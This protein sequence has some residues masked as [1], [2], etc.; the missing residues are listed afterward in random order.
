MQNHTTTQDPRF[1]AIYK[2]HDADIIS[3]RS[4]DVSLN[5]LTGGQAAAGKEI[6]I[7]QTSHAFLF[8]S[9]GFGVIPLVN[10]FLKGEEKELSEKYTELLLDLCNFVTLPF[11]WGGFEPKRGEPNTKAI[12]AA[13]RWLKDRGLTVKGHPLCWHTLCAPWLLEMDNSEILKTQLARIERDVTD[14]KG[15]IDMWDVINEAVIMPIFD[16][17]DNG[18]TR[19][20]NEIGRLNLIRKTFEEA[21]KANS[22]ATL[23]INDFD[24]T[25]PYEILI[26]GCL[27]AGIPIDCIGIQSHMHQGYW[28][29]EKTLQILERYER[30]GL[31]IHFSETTIISGD[32]MPGEIVDL[33]DYKRDSWPSTPEGEERQAE[34]TVLHYRTLFSRKLVK[35]ITWWDLIDG[36]WLNAPSGLIRADCS[37][38]PAYKELLKLIKEEWRGK[39]T[40]LAADDSGTI[41]FRAF[42]GTYEISV[43]GKTTR[44]EI[45]GD[46]SVSLSASL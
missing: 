21:R 46:G 1:T 6:T 15:V 3:A 8:G 20:C 38:K 36:H 19:V 41:R 12:M 5:I 34:E 29:V 17:Y 4:L 45:D 26:E 16:K 35:G 25:T 42:A 22:G 28:G 23:L 11:Y 24:Y 32:I 37:P 44:V 33:N 39:K 31:P 18:M 10:G 30:F 27:E 43:D 9:N 40:T 14:F 13:A 7:E 2:T